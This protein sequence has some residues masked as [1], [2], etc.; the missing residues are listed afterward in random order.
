[1][2]QNKENFIN[3]ISNEIFSQDLFKNTIENFLIKKQYP[4]Y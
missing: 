3:L 4:I 2:D 1:M